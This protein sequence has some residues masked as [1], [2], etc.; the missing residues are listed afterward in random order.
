MIPLFINDARNTLTYNSYDFNVPIG[1]SD[2]DI[3]EV[4]RIVQQT[5]LAS[6]TERHARDDGMEA[7]A[8]YKAQKRLI[9]SGMVR[10]STRGKL[11]DRLDEVAAAFDPALV[12]RANPDEA[13]FLGLDF[14][15]PTADTDTYAT[16]LIACR[17]YVRSENAFEPPITQHT[18]LSLPFVLSLLAV[19]PRRYKQD[20]ESLTGAGTADNSNA[21]YW[22]WPTI[23]ITMAGAGSAI[24]AIGN[25]TNS[26]LLTIDLSGTVDDDVIDIDMHART[27]K[28]N[29]TSSP[30][31]YVSG[32]FW[33][34]E[35]GSNT[36]TVENDTNATAV[37]TWR[38]AFSF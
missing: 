22:S 37:T 2:K 11:H 23:Q 19:D 20:T 3:V 35:A 4:N 6:I 33:A 38:P 29:S 10:A 7:Y 18:G 28:K 8:A 16:G 24:F 13:G 36:L 32:D 31:L 12:S 15:V 21:S 25:S 9:L 1:G 5:A 26:G 30:S 14:N 34:I 17:Y 27:I